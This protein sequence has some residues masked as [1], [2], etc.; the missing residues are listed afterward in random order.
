VERQS[1]TVTDSIYGNV[2][3][4]D[5]DSLKHRLTPIAAPLILI[6][7]AVLLL[8]PTLIIGTHFTHSSAQNLTWAA[9]F[10]EQFRAGVLYPRW[11][12]DSFE[13][14]GG[15]TFYFYPPLAFWIDAAT[16]VVTANLLPL[17]YRLAVTSM[18]ILFASGIAMYAWLVRESASRSIALWGAVG[19]M[20]APYHLLDHYM[21]GALAEFTAYASLPIAVLGVRLIAER[22]RSGPAILAIGYAALIA[23]H[24]PTALLAT[25]TVIAAYVLYH[26]LQDPGTLL[27]C[28]M[29]GALGVALAAVYL[30]PSLTLQGWISA[31]AW[32]SS[33]YR[34][35]NW[36]LLAPGRWPERLLMLTIASISAAV[37]LVALGLGV[38]W[39]RR[40]TSSA[41]RSELAFWIAA[42]FGC[43]ALMAGFV[44][45]FWQIDVIAKV[46][47]PWR[48]LL[49][50][51]FT[52]ITALCLVPF[53]AVGRIET[54]I[55]ATA[56][57][58]LTPA[59]AYEG[60][61]AV[62]RFKFTLETG[63]L[64][65]R[66]ARPNEPRGFP[67][68]PEAR[69]DDLGLEPLANVPTISCLPAAV[70]CRAEPQRFGD[71]QIDVESDRPT[72]VVVRRF[73]FP[74]WQ[75]MP[76]HTIV[77][78]EPFRLVS[79]VVPPGRQGFLLRRQTLPAERW[80]WVISAMALVLLL[81]WRSVS[82]VSTPRA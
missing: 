72:T 58:V 78:T 63:T 34:P 60:Y 35:D 43:L 82:F 36:F 57:L 38:I 29:A 68:K 7:T 55:F 32:W 62:A 54:Y 30:L 20:A 66:D 48:M 49:L 21:R 67:Q 80:G 4:E 31:D 56:L 39:A 51:E 9:Q 75:L 2:A 26:G 3:G 19:Y 22:R 71:M 15:P 14:L 5:R 24:L 27:R 42:T 59:I 8:L 46:Q 37:A 28:V 52:V 16:S 74:A 50:V 47:F 79:F 73:Y 77:P 53:H 18:V 76:F 45:W 25:C 33:L 70:I 12:P 61:D 41:Q 65:Q 1:R 64:D 13:G 40:S 81:V 6:G 44:P 17:P 69:Y 10:A 11:M 23:S